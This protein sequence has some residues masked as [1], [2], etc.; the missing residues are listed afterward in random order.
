MSDTL[1]RARQAA[2]AVKIETTKGTDVIAGSPVAADFVRGDCQV[3]FDQTTVPD[4]QYTGSL[5]GAPPIVGGTRPRFTIRM[6]LRG[7]GTAGTAP[8]WG[9]LLQCCTMAETVTASS[10]GAPTA[11]AAGSTTTGTLGAP[12]GTTA[13]QYT[14]MP[15]VMGAVT[16]DQ[17]SITGVTNYTTSKVATFLHTVATTW[18]TTQTAQVPINVRYAP[19]SDETVYK[20]CTVYVYMDGLLWEFAGCTGSWGLEL[21]TGGIGFLTFN[22]VGTFDG[23]SATAFPAAAVASIAQTPPRFVAGV[24]RLNGALCR[25]RTLTFDAGVGTVLPDN[26]EATEGYDPAIPIERN[27]SGALDPLMD[28]TTS[29]GLFTNFR[30]GVNMRL[31]AIIGS[32]AGNRF[33]LLMPSARVIRNNPTAREGLGVNGMAF[34]ADGADAGAYI[35]QF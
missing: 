21:T 6:A 8:E 35:A 2:V 20:T 27:M 1:V 22:M 11:L 10:V 18:T 28:T 26:P 30:T 31:G 13:Q 25:V 3:T 9:R 17:P 5:D 29:V 19:T 4:P 32:A 7:S 12:F 16:G 34:Q 23:F 15:I 33:A 14:G 24:M